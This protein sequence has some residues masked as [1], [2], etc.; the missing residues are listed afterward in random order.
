[1]Y[2]NPAVTY[3]WYDDSVEM[4]DKVNERNSNIVL[5]GDFNIDLLKFHSAWA[6][7][8]SMF[9]LHQLIR[10]ATRRTQTTTT[11]LDHIYTNNEHMVSN[12]Q[13]S[14]ICMSDHCP[15]I[16]TWSCKPPKKLA[17]GHTSVQS[18]SFKHF[19]ND[20]FLRDLSSAPFAAVFGAADP[21]TAL[22]IWYDGFLPVIEKHAPLRRKRVK[23]P[24][25]PQWLSTDIITA[26]KTRD[27]LKKEK[28]FDDYK[29]YRS[30]VTNLVQAAKKAYYEKLINHNKDTSALW[31]AMNEI[32][33]KSR[34]KSASSEIKCSPNSF[35]E[36]FLSLSESVLKS[37]NSFCKDYE[38]SPLLDRKVLSR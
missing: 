24:T 5:L 33:R 22:I 11:L 12:A 23:H 34:N 21:T 36:H 35:N 27:K 3:A 18:R 16:C 1:M 31:K 25:L 6:S 19:D 29:K 9:G 30:K 13:V 32:T 20:D 26:M 37:T 8:T 38:I 28:K 2:R 7:T 15:V 17:K 4:M 10:C 14:N